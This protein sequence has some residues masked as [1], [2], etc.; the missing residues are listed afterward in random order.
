LIFKGQGTKQN[1]TEAIQHLEKAVEHG[2][3][4]AQVA[5]GFLFFLKSD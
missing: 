4:G 1:I 2:L 5:L 3:I